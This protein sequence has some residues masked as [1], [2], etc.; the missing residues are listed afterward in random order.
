MRLPKRSRGILLGAA[1]LVAGPIV[2]LTVV[3]APGAAVTA[4][5][6]QPPVLGQNTANVVGH[7]IPHMLR[8]HAPIPPPATPAPAPAPV[9]HHTVYRAAA[10][11]VPAATYSPNSVEGIITA[12][13]NRW[14]VSASWMI[15]IARCESGLRPNAYN[16]HGPYYGLF[17]FLMSTFTHNG[18][19]NI[20]DP[21]DQA[22][23]AAKMLA[24]GQAHQWSC[25]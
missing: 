4:V 20:W 1:A 14:G 10:P 2:A 7:P 17:Q 23:I 19:T 18:G 12:A 11:A 22:N 15:S 24:H 16:P 3:A 25:A 13:A 9:Q 21:A 8:N 5:R 6:V